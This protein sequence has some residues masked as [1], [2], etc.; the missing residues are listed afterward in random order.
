MSALTPVAFTVGGWRA[1]KFRP[2]LPSSRRF[3]WVDKLTISWSTP[4]REWRA[5]EGPGERES[6]EI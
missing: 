5:Q 6:A 4:R 2:L 1:K 3:V